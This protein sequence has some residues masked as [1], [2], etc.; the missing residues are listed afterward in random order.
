[1]LRAYSWHTYMKNSKTILIIENQ[2]KINTCMSNI[3]ITDIKIMTYEV[4]TMT[5]KLEMGSF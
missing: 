4:M 5:L 1:M 2:F 3:N